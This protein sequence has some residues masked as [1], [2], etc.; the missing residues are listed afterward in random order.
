M[1]QFNLLPD[2]KLQFVRAKRQKR[3]V[4][5]ISALVGAA[6]LGIMILLVGV[7]AVQKKHLNDVNKDIKKYTNDLKSTPELD[8]ILTIQNQLKTLPELHN[9]KPVISRIFGYMTQIIPA[10]VNIASLEVN[11]DEY[12]MSFSGTAD[13]V[14]TVNK[15]IDTLKFTTFTIDDTEGANK[16][17]SEVVLSSYAP[18]DKDT[19]Y[20]VTLKFDP[21]LFDSSKKVTL[22]VPK[23]TT[24]RSETEKPGDLFKQQSP[25]TNSNGAQ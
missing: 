5:V 4:V 19:S 15:L 23:I 21:V 2:V 1:I 17:F 25:A 11:F 6:S 13:S 20:A 3:N 16:P 7:N 9:K 10:Q 8:K 14:V 12:T 24:T 18:A 22:T